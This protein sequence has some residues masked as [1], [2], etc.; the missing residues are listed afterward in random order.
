MNKLT[1]V[2]VNY[3][4]TDCLMDCL[5][6][7][8]EE[9][10]CDSYQVVVV[11]NASE[12]LDVPAL[13]AWQTKVG[14][15]QNSRNLGFATACNQG[16]RAHPAQFYLLLNPDTVVREAAIDK[17]LDF[18]KLTAD[19]GIAGCRVENPDGT[20]QMACRRSIPR[21]AMAVYRFLGLSRLFPNSVRF[22]SY[23]LTFLDE[24]TTHPVEA[25]SGSFLMF[26][27]ELLKD[28]GFLDE[29]F[30]LYGEDLDFCY[31]SL[32]KGWKNYYF[33]HAWITHHKRRSSGRS[34]GQAIRHFYDA[35]RI[36][37]RKHYAPRSSGLFNAAV[38]A[39]IR[40]L[41]L[42]TRAWQFLTGSSGVGS[43]H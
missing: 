8:L 6:S 24:K 33:A 31:R 15:V 30:F 27:H 23:N 25:V 17:T 11:D 9:T 16:L 7:V 3:N 19:A 18:L 37:Y 38:Y 42:R 34:P 39:A 32:L 40:I 28:I 20:L 10:R 35:M 21:P 22:S 12:D 41:Y 36:F 14:W 4:S 5:Q 13:R 29:D 26:R 1:I 43:S 2:I